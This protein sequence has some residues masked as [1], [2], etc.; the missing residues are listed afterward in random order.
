MDIPKMN[1]YKKAILLWIVMV[2]GLTLSCRKATEKTGKSPGTDWIKILE[3]YGE[4]IIEDVDGNLVVAGRSYSFSKDGTTEAYLAKISN[5]GDILWNRTYPHSG[6]LAFIDEVTQTA[7]SG[8]IMVGGIYFKMPY[9]KLYVVRTDGDGRLIWS[10]TYGEAKQH[11]EACVTEDK[12]GNFLIGGSTYSWTS[13]NMPHIKIEINI[14]CMDQKGDILWSKELIKE[15]KEECF[16]PTLCADGKYL[17]IGIDYGEMHLLR[18]DSMSD[19][20]LIRN[21]NRE[22]ERYYANSV[23]TVSDGG[24]IIAGNK[25][26]EKWPK[27]PAWP[28]WPIYI[29]IFADPVSECF[30]FGQTTDFYLV[31]VDEKGSIIWTKEFGG[32]YQDRAN[33]VQQT[34]DGDY[35]ISG[36]TTKKYAASPGLIVIDG[37]YGYIGKT[38]RYGEIVWEEEIEI[39]GADLCSIIQTNDG[40]CAA[41]GDFWIGGYFK[42]GLLV[43]L[44]P[45]E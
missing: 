23:K 38:D 9:C 44:K 14:I 31:K 40:G 21:V 42:K 1:H 8:Y 33:C 19:S 6:G 27:Y 22:D 28:F 13:P 39:D 35:I 45:E 32:K 10:H 11:L 26:F 20:L 41:T 43:K 16:A 12:N 30:G 24:Y 5:A 4:S 18:A 15:G 17:L 7:D 25:M 36:Y 37:L 2:V 3:G 34:D 29:P